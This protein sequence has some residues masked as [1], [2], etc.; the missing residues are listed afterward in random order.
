MG[1]SEA[2]PNPVS[3]SA[4]SPDSQH[5]VPGAI[6]PRFAQ[7]TRALSSRAKLVR[8]GDVPVLLA[9]PNWRSETSSPC[10]VMLWMHGRTV[11]KEIDPGRYVRWLRAGIAVCA[12]DLPGHGERLDAELQKPTRTLEVLAQAVDEINSIVTNLKSARWDEHGP[13]GLFDTTR[14][15]IGGM[16]AGGM[17]TLRRL[18]E[19]HGFACAAV[20]GTTGWLDALY[21]PE[22]YEVMP[23]GERW[24]VPHDAAAVAR[25]DSMP[26][27]QAFRPIPILAMHSEADAIVPLEG[28]RRYLDA[29]REAYVMKGKD[30]GLIRLVTW[31]TTGAPGEHAGFGRYA[32][33]AK[34]IQTE[35]L[36]N[37]LGARA[38]DNHE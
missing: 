11:S 8:F 14:M 5:R 4:G 13:L 24:A 31:P 2:T 28:Q 33:D 19:P 1:E 22:A 32:T 35:Y 7:F 17:V 9:H 21:T 6:H 29:L 36:A 15:G 20:E 30:P 38:T 18:S 16:S 23:R 3:F 10:P 27:V 37:M 34:T 25:V 26:H 12:I